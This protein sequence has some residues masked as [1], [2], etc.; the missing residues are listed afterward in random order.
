MTPQE[1]WNPK[2]D[3]IAE[4]EIEPDLMQKNKY[5]VQNLMTCSA[6]VQEVSS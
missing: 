2:G 4:A 6:R 5:E 3:C 1:R